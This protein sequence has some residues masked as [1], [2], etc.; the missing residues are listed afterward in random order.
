MGVYL[1]GTGVALPEPVLTESEVAIG[2]VEARLARRL[3]I[4]SVCTSELS[5]A[6]V[7][8]RAAI[9]C[10]QAAGIHPDDIETVLH[11]S[12]YHQ[13]FDLWSSAAYVQHI[14]LPHSGAVALDVGQLSNGAMAA[15]ELG[16]RALEAS[17]PTSAILITTGDRFVLPGV[18][19]WH[20]D[21]GTV[22]A[23]GGTAAIFSRQL[24]WAELLSLRGH[25]SPKLEEMSRGADQPSAAPLA[26]RVPIDI[27]L[28]R[29]SLVNEF[30]L[31]ELL[32]KLQEGQ[33]EVYQ[34]AL[35]EAGLAATDIDWHVV[36]H[37][38][39]PK[40]EHQFFEPLSIDRKRSTWEWGRGIGHLG[41]GDQWAG[42][43][44]LKTSG[45][46]RPG[47]IVAVHGAGGGFYWSCGVFKVLDT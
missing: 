1:A 22:F 29:E 2:H 28:G 42:L 33:T 45:R 40:M 24:G 35:L 46:A 37:L 30:G 32:T 20:T 31:E 17:S 19:R 27:S 26:H 21:P 38:G 36:P 34:T 44:W 14:A 39:E 7:G 5:G 9:E 10:V 18:D 13:G 6:E 11:A 8:A 47:D 23:D 3:G 15:L 12:A 43:H 4:T 16:C 25:G 41:A